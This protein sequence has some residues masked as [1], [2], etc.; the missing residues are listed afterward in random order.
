MTPQLCQGGG[1]AAGPGQLPFPLP[2]PSF[3]EVVWAREL[4]MGTCC[5]TTPHPRHRAPPVLHAL[6]SLRRL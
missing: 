2:L 3:V 4:R 6:P 5:Q 1:Q